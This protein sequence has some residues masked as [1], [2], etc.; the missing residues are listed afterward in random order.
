MVLNG[1][2]QLPVLILDLLNDFRDPLFKLAFGDFG[3]QIDQLELTL[4]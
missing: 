1:I 2:Y 4:R 3:V